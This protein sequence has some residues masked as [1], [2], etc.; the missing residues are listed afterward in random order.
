MSA[1]FSLTAF[2]QQ[3]VNKWSRKCFSGR[4]G[5][6]GK[7]CAELVTASLGKQKRRP[8]L[9]LAL[10]YAKGGFI[11]WGQRTHTRV[12]GLRQSPV[13]CPAPVLLHNLYL[14]CKG[15]CVFSPSYKAAARLKY[16]SDF[17][18]TVLINLQVGA[19][20]W[21]LQLLFRSAPLFCV[22]TVEKRK[23]QKDLNEQILLWPVLLCCKNWLLLSYWNMVRGRK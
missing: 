3:G 22:K 5:L 2:G 14:N 21:E 1:V 6:K 20:R 11:S 19:R 15:M 18:Q 4:A 12:S 16:A 7:N 10:P 9:R 23:Q 17:P 8:G 13:S